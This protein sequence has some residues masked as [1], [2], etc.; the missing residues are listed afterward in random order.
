MCNT[1]IVINFYIAESVHGD[2]TLTTPEAMS[3]TDGSI[4]MSPEQR[5]EL[6]EHLNKIRSIA[7]SNLKENT[8]RKFKETK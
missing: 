3:D 8:V 5:L 7:L 6:Q 2:A 1:P 4:Y